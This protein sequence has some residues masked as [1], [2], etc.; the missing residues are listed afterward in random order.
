[1]NKFNEINKLEMIKEITYRI[2]EN[3]KALLK[4]K[5]TYLKCCGPE[6]FKS[7][8][9]YRDYDT[10]H[11]SKKEYTVESYVKEKVRL[12][13]IIELDKEIL[14]NI[15]KEIDTEEYLKLLTDNKQ[16]VRFLRIIKRYTQSQTAEIIGISERQV[17]RIE[18]NI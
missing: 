11:G 13:N 5:D 2:E 4:L 7:G 12:E 15:K 9:S 8:T 16:K 10:I 6:G 14:S 17:R 3:T 18:K 1:M